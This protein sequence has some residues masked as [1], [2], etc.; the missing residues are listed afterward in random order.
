M[1]ELFVV[2]S[3]ADPRAAPPRR[4]HRERSAGELDTAGLTSFGVTDH[5]TAWV[6]AE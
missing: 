5:H 3:D 4:L 2:V 6:P 1:K